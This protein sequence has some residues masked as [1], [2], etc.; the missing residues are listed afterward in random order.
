MTKLPNILFFGIDSLRRTR[1]SEYGYERLTTPHMSN[2]IKNGASFTQ[3]FSASIPTT[4]GYCCMLTG[5]DCFGTDVV[6]LR[7][8]AHNNEVAPGV[9]MLSEILKENGYNTSCIQFKGNAGGRGYDTYLEFAGWGPDHDDGR[10]HKAQNCNDVVIPE[11]ERLQAEGKPWFLFMRYMD[12]HSPY[13]AP[14]PFKDMFFQGVYDDPDDKSLEGLFNFKPFRDYIRSWIPEGCTSA[15]YVDAQYD[16]AV[17]YLDT[18]INQVIVKMQAMGIEED[19]LVVFVSDHGETLNEHDCYYDHH[20]LYEPTLTVPF[21]LVW[22]GHIAPGQ[23]FDNICQLKDVTPTILDVLGIDKGPFH[24]NGRSLSPLMNGETIVAED[25]FYITECTWMRKHGWR[26]PEWKLIRALEPDL[27]FKPPIE[28]YNLI[29][30]PKELHNLADERPEIVEFYTQK[31]EAYIAKR[32]AETGRTNPMY[33]N[34][35]WHANP[36]HNGPYE[37]SQQAYD[38]LYIGSVAQ[39]VSLQQKK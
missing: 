32:E 2:Y 38:G 31:M 16:A 10:A 15:D 37:T 24:F 9:K 26:T 27:H 35:N 36:N 11:M 18:A 17:A 28:L 14:A 19:T 6:A 33:T 23:R 4:P 39:A 7:H 13:L 1:M 3:M 12:P 5:Q 30:D 29:D 21:A 20:G 22:K 25:E 34:L 8:T